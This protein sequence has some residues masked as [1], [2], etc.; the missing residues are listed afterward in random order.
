MVNERGSKPLSNYHNNEAQLRHQGELKK[1]LT[2]RK[3][4][5]E[6]IPSNKKEK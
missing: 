2:R 6:K 4:K 5:G 3:Q 1:E